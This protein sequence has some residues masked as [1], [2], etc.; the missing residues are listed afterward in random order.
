MSQA[1]HLE[2]FYPHPP[3]R[4]W[5]V[6]TNRRALA[7]WMMENDFEPKL[8]HKFRFYNQPLPGLK[9]TIQCEVVELEEPTRLVYTWQESPTT[10]PSLVVWTLTTVAGGTQLRLKHHQYSYTTAVAS[11]ARPDTVAHTYRGSELSYSGKSFHSSGVVMNSLNADLSRAAQFNLP[12]IAIA[13]L[14]SI[15]ANVEWNYFL[16]RT[17]PDL[18][19]QD[20]CPEEPS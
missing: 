19:E 6:L 18:L 15:P 17:L 4:V 3:E 20:S 14:T 8:G 16:N 9:T 12:G 13:P 10:E 1:V 2:V 5:Q 11:S 7:N